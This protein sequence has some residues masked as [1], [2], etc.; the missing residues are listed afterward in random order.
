MGKDKTLS[1]RKNNQVLSLFMKIQEYQKSANRTE[2]IN[3]AIKKA[4]ETRV[5]WKEITDS[6]VPKFHVENDDLPEFIQLRVDEDEYKE[7]V[8]QMRSDFTLEK[9]SPAPFVV[10]LLLI[11]YLLY[12]ESLPSVESEIARKEEEKRKERQKRI[13]DFSKLTTDDKL[14]AL[15]DMLLDIKEN[16]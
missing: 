13:D 11:K 3:A 1:I 14:C 15:Y 9:D 7:I 6:K 8:S 16:T 12:L 2:I 10:K 5:N 4:L